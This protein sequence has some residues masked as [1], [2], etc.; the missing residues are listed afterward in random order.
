MDTKIF[1]YLI[2]IYSDLPA[3]ELNFDFR[4]QNWLKLLGFWTNKE[5][6]YLHNIKNYMNAILIVEG[7][8][9]KV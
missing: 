9:L 3:H 6:N 1:L 2:I 5:I 4:I 7:F 8:I